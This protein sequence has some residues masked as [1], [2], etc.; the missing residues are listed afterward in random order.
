MKKVYLALILAA[1]VAGLSSCSKQCY[2]KATVD[3]AEVQGN[4]Y[5]LEE[6]KKCS[7]YSYRGVWKAAQV[8]YTCSDKMYFP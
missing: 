1:C 5:F 3:G 8:E 2:C 4:T 7:D 6:G